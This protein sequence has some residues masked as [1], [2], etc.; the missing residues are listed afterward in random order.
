[1]EKMNVWK[2]IANMIKAEGIEFVFGIGDTGL[3]LH[4]EKVPGIK[5]IN[6]RYEGSA[7]FMAMAYSRLS[8][9]PGVCTA[10]PGPGVANLV[11]GV[12]EAYSGCSPL[13][14]F[15]HSCSQKLEG[16]GDFQETDQVSLMRPITKWSVRIPYAERIPW[17]VR[18]AFSLAMNGQPGPVFLE[19]P[20][21]VTGV[22]KYIS[23]E[24][25]LPDYVPAQ[26]L[27]SA[28]DPEKIQG[29]AEMLLKLKRPIAVAG[30]GAVLSQATAQFREL[31]ELLGIPFMTTPGGR[32]I[33]S[34]QHPLALGTTGLYRTKVGKTVYN[35]SDLLITIGTRNE[36]FETHAWED[37]PKGAKYIQIDISPSEI[38]RNWVPD[39]GIAGDARIVLQQLIDA[40]R[41]R[42][43]GV[44][45]FSELSR[46]QE[47][48]KA[49]AEFEKEVK[50]E[51]RVEE[52]PL[53]AKRIINDVSEAFGENTIVVSEN[54]GQDTWSYCFP[55]YKLHDGSEWVPVA[56]QTCMGMGVVGAIAAKLTKPEK[57]VVCITGDGA[58]QMYM[59][60]LPTATQYRVGCTWIVLNNFAFGWPKS[61]QIDAVGW[62]TLSFDAQPDFM[63]WAEACQCFGRRVEK[64]SEI[65]PALEEAIRANSKGI[66]AVLEFITGL[67]L[68]H[69]ERA[70]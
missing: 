4:T 7:P 38:G 49:K 17:F 1:M 35:D 29:A 68:T 54:G 45:D 23:S 16:M 47:I 53:P 15:G 18:R 13:V 70:K 11:P 69:F 57:K 62:D 9:R 50:A 6:L 55:Y 43:A 25:S 3:Q 28:G 56:E 37:Y 51:C 44:S 32:G 65:R 30:N 19:F 64:P 59:K 42:G 2:A 63:K 60:E 8:N 41:E 67:D 26:K 36:S 52:T 39:I 58:F 14:V 40:I 31:V 46:V 24:L 33:V 21:D 20:Y 12:L 34:E 66:P 27:R 5:T 61:G 10:S 22:S 48:I